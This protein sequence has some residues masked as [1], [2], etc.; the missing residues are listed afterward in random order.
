ML[1]AAG[2]IVG[3]LWYKLGGSSE[4]RGSTI[5]TVPAAAESGEEEYGDDKDGGL[6]ADGGVRIK[7]LGKTATM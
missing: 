5:E 4:Y 1:G 7:E 2:C 6:A 3:L